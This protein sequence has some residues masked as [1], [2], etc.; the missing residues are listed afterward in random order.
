VCFRCLRNTTPAGGVLAGRPAPNDAAT[1]GDVQLSGPDYFLQPKSSLVLEAVPRS[2][3]KGWLVAAHQKHRRSAADQNPVPQRNARWMKPEMLELRT[4]DLHRISTSWSAMQ[5]QCNSGP[6]LPND[7]S[8]AGCELSAC[9]LAQNLGHDQ[10]DNGC[11]SY[12]G[13]Q[14]FCKPNHAGLK[15]GQH[16]SPHTP[17]HQQ[18]ARQCC[19]H[20]VRSKVV[21]GP[22]VLAHI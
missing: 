16:A 10:D 18:R 11:F 22:Q 2:R 6:T 14:M 8:D 21:L 1:D 3:R 4:C 13:F 15:Q 19:S 20:E 9:N 5:S 12:T 7:L 17:H